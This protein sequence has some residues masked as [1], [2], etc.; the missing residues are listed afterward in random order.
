MGTGLRASVM[1]H[2]PALEKAGSLNRLSGTLSKLG[3]T[4]RGTYGEGTKA[5][6]SLYQISN[7]ITLGISEEQAIKTCVKL[8]LRLWKKNGKHKKRL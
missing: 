6:G 4:M 5:V 3:L 2:I 1:L 7:Q 8:C